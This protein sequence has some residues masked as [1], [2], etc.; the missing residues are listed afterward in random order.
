[1]KKSIEKELME[2]WIIVLKNYIN[3]I[4]KIYNIEVYW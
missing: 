2:N 1:M 3:L 4:L